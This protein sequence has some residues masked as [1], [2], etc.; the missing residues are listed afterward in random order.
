[1]ENNMFDNIFAG[2]INSNEVIL[3]F[4]EKELIEALDQVMTIVR[5]P[6]FH[7]SKFL[8]ENNANLNEIIM[9]S[10]IELFAFDIEALDLSDEMWDA[11]YMV[12]QY[13]FHR[14]TTEKLYFKG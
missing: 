9:G 11:L 6:D 13:I 4:T 10:A 5:Q 12:K 1:M 8:T 14:I 7:P 3:S 2:H